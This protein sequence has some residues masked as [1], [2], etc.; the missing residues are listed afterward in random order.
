MSIKVA[1]IE[2]TD[3]FTIDENG[4]PQAP[5]IYQIQNKDIREL[6]ERDKGSI[7]DINGT[8]K[9]RYKKE[10]GVIYYLGDPKSPANQMGY[11]KPEAIELAKANYGLPADWQP[12]KLILSLADQYKKTKLGPAGEVYEATSRA[13]HN[14][15]LVANALNNIL[16]EKLLS[17]VTIEDASALV[18]IINSVNKLISDLPNQTKAH[19]EALQNLELEKQTKVARGKVKITASMNASDAYDLQAQAEAEKNR[20]GLKGN[21]PLNNTKYELTK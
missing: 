17:G 16:S 1:D 14:S 21:T 18:G 6:W 10:A 4:I 9:L 15:A 13:L 5:N 11:S 12:D 7:G 8:E 20:L 3:L 2:L 19:A